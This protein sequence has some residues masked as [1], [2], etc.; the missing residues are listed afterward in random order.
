MYI[1]CRTFDGN[2]MYIWTC[3]VVDWIVLGFRC[4]I[5]LK[6]E[7]AQDFNDAHDCTDPKTTSCF[8]S[9]YSFPAWECM[10]VI[11]I[12]LEGLK[13]PTHNNFPTSKVEFG[14]FWP[15]TFSVFGPFQAVVLRNRLD[16]TRITT[17]GSGRLYAV[18]R[19]ILV[20]NP[21]AV[22]IF[23]LYYFIFGI[24]Q[25]LYWI[26]RPEIARCAFLGFGLNDGIGSLYI[27]REK[28]IWLFLAKNWNLF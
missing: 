12:T 7:A 27:T 13:S 18:G 11:K 15:K 24:F 22:T 19:I 10:P 5:M 4:E 14:S 25:P 6:T 21:Y 16:I 20:C 26:Y 17:T 1:L 9:V 8:Q 23:W 3:T 28:Q 2:F